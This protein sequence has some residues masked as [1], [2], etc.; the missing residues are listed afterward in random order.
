MKKIPAAV[1]PFPGLRPAV[2]KA[3][4][5]LGKAGKGLWRQIQ[6][7][8]NITDAGGCAHLLQA[9]RA[10]DDI[11]RWREIVDKDGPVV[12]DRFGQK[13]AHPLVTQIAIAES[14]RRA[15]LHALNLNVEPL[16]D[17]PGRPSG[18]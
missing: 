5:G 14:V 1:I 11:A 8:Y 13:K 12:F 15:A 2:Q 6:R 9:S 4:K 18:K 17:G 7:E 16:Q 10:E 3:P